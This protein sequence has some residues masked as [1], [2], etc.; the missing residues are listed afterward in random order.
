MFVVE[1]GISKVIRSV[2]ALIVG[3]ILYFLVFRNADLTTQFLIIFGYL[4]YYVWLM[5]EHLVI[6]GK[7]IDTSAKIMVGVHTFWG[8]LLDGIVTFFTDIFEA[9]NPFPKSDAPKN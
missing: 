2:I 5:M 1:M 3:I 8:D 7:P 6:E 9:I 4:V